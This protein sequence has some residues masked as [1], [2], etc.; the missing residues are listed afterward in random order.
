MTKDTKEFVATCSLPRSPVQTGTEG[1]APHYI[2][3]FEVE[4]NN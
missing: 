3:P 4:K 2:G 1:V